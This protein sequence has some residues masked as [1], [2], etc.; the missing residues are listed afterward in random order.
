MHRP[1]AI[2]LGRSVVIG[3]LCLVL[4]GCGVINP[5]PPRAVVEGAIAQKLSQTQIILYRQLGRQ[6]GADPA[7]LAQVSG[8]R[9][10]DHHWT[11]IAGQPAVEVA[12]TYHLKGGGLT[13]AQRRQTR[14]FDVYLQRGT[15]KDQWRLLEPD[16]DQPG[17]SLQWRATPIDLSFGAPAALSSCCADA[18]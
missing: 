1:A 11:E 4:L 13:S 17:A 2:Y 3:L 14:N 15:A 5:R 16:P 18:P 12:G 8:I 7:D 10:A 6:A 9:I